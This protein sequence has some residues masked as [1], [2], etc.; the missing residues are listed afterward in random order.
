MNTKSYNGKRYILTFIDDFTHFT[1]AYPLAK[2]K[3]EVAHYFKE[4][5][6]MAK[7]HY[8]SKISRVRCD[9]DRKYISAEFKTKCERKEIRMKYTISYTPQQ[10]NVTER[11][12]RTIIERAKCLILDSHLGK[13]FWTE[14]VLTA[15]YL[16]NQS[17]TEPLKNTVAASDMEVGRI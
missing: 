4:Y 6:A 3:R 8:D 13:R 16:I 17:P 12:N 1:V 5:I 10:N 15:V 14:A 2:K 9:N 7:A 11:M